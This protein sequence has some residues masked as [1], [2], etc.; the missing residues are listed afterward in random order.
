M[1]QWDYKVFTFDSPRK[2]VDL[3]NTLAQQGKYGWELVSLTPVTLGGTAMEMVA[4]F[5]RPTTVPA[6]PEPEIDYSDWRSRQ[7]AGIRIP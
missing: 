4:V 5:K 3:S 7:A 6:E 2:T 1:Q